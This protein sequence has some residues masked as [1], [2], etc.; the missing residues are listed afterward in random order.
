MA[1]RPRR[2]FCCDFCGTE[3]FKIGTKYWCFE[4]KEDTWGTWGT[5]PVYVICRRY[6]CKDRDI[7]K[8][9]SLWE[10]TWDG[11]YEYSRSRR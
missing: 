10:R 8:K 5:K 4:E 6:E 3:I 11:N 2:K 7:T 9:E 1:W